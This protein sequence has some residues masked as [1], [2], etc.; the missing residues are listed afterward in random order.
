VHVAAGHYRSLPEAAGM[1]P[2]MAQPDATFLK[3]A[4]ALKPRLSIP[5]IAVGRLGEP[6][7]AQAALADAAC[8]FIVLGRPLLADPDWSRKVR[9]GV[10]VRRCIACNTCVSGMRRG[11][12]LHCLVNAET[13][14]EVDHA[15]RSPPRGKRIAVLGAGPAGLTY[16]SLVGA[17]N[18]V[19]VFER[20]SGPRRA[21]SQPGRRHD[22]KGWKRQNAR[23]RAML[24]ASRRSAHSPACAIAA[25]WTSPKSPRSSPASITWWW[26]PAALIGRASV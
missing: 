13:R 2:P 24:P 9:A 10:P 4:R 11:G 1:I 19:V 17:A 3:F 8:D 14:R 25:A 6:A 22:F 15:D 26:P 16:A 5:V 23:S 12:P 20:A 18:D 21:A 7:I